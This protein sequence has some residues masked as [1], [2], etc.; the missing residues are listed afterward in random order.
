MVGLIVEYIPLATVAL[1]GILTVVFA[2]TSP[3]KKGSKK[4]RDRPKHVDVPKAA[5]KRLPGGKGYRI[6]L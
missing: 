3:V 1:V 6:K 5:V 2:L 4:T